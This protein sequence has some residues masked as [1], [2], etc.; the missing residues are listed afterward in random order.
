MGLNPAQVLTHEKAMHLA[1][2]SVL[3]SPSELCVWYGYAGQR[4]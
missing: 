4:G 3:P 2:P 1:L